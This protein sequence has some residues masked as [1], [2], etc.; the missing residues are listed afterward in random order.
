MMEDDYRASEDELAIRSTVSKNIRIANPVSLLL[1]PY[2]VSEAERTGQV[3]KINMI[4][5]DDNPLSPNRAKCEC[6]IEYVLLKL[7]LQ[8]N[9]PG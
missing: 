1:T 7:L 5:P 4:P 6:I 8:L 2:N 3:M 9:I